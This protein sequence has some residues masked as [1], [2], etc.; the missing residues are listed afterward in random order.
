MR[1]EH[2]EIAG[3]LRPFGAQTYV[4]A[5]SQAC[6]TLQ[7]GLLSNLPSGK[8]AIAIAFER[9][10]CNSSNESHSCE[11]PGSGDIQWWGTL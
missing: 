1:M 7:P 8:K 6:A 2:F 4:G 10:D 5:P 3:S 9:V 11:C